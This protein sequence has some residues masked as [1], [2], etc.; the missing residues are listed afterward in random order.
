[1]R[2]R[3]V[4]AWGILA[5]W[6]GLLGWHFRREHFQPELARLTEGMATLDPGTNF[7]A[8]RMGR[9][10]IGISSSRLD[11]VPEGFVLEDVMTLEL[12][13]MGQPGAAV[14]RTEVLLGPT[15]D[16]TDFSF[17][18]DSEAGTFSAQGTI[19]GD[20]IILVELD[21]GGG[22]EELSFRV[23]E[24]PLLTAAL[25]I[26]LAKSGELAVGR[27]LRLLV[28]DPSA[29]SLR[30][31]E[32]EVLE[33]GLLTVPDS[34]ALDPGTGRWVAVTESQLPAWRVR[35]SFGG[36]SIESWIDEDGRVIQ[37]SSN[38][39]FS[40]E[41]TAYEL[42]LQEQEDTRRLAGGGA[43]ASDVIF[44][45]A[46][47]SN[48]LI[49]DP[50]SASELRFVLSGM[51]LQGFHLDG[52]RQE[53]RGDTL[54]VRREDW[55]VV[56]ADYGLPYPRM[57]LRE[58]LEPEPLIQSGD[59][60]IQEVTR[61]I[62][63]TGFRGQGNP[64]TVARRLTDGVY[65]LLD[66]EVSFS[67][68]SATQVLRTLGGDC[69]EHTVLYVALAR[70]VGLPARVAV[71]LVYLEG[72]FYYHAWPEVWLDEWVAVDPTFGQVPADAAHLRFITGGFAQQLE[73]ARL[74]GALRIEVL[75]AGA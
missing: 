23:Q 3:S 6:V 35:E 4:A 69:N 65:E 47:A 37:S 59:P 42:A 34:A 57:D 48:R 73:V 39:G 2:T 55:N 30:T 19:E 56:A 63:R 41:R 25:P 10:V 13:A 50:T 67:I 51:D 9:E 45:T 46:I 75:D 14:A 64:R 8:L 61:Y 12:Q 1:M 16:M 53:L 22:V 5:I 74:I 26:R 43:V 68:P 31:V 28:F 54:I 38:M 44:S 66:K 49:T 58:A 27:T 36:M 20:S 7:Y 15:L 11:T 17:T 33:Q 32:I 70:A 62:A 24:A 21:T 18:L 60:R 72:A 52:G 29:V 71:G 40:I